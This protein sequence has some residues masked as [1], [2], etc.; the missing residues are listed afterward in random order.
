MLLYPEKKYPHK[1]SC[2]LLKEI[3]ASSRGT[4]DVFK[5]VFLSVLFSRQ[6]KVF[7]LHFFLMWIPWLFRCCCKS[8]NL[9]SAP[10]AV[11]QRRS[12]HGNLEFTHL[13]CRYYRN[14]VQ[15]YLFFSLHLI[16]WYIFLS[17]LSSLNRGQSF[18][19]T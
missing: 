17:F 19:I 12:E 11:W 10:I 6:D 5:E 13:V 4:S 15:N 9:I 14:V 8:G 1:S 2:D 16:N 7:H 3:K 18:S